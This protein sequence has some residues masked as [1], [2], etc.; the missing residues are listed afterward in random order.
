LAMI[1]AID[2]QVGLLVEALKARRLIDNTVIFF[3]SDNGATQET[4]ADHS[5]RPYRGGSNA[6]YRGWKQ[7][8]FE[9]GVRMPSFVTWP[10]RIKAG[11]TL[12]EIG[13][14]MDVMPTFLTMAGLTPPPDLDGKDQKAM[15]MGQG[16]S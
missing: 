6:P 11:Q 3:Q 15:W 13:M 16:K 9:G 4:R 8:L 5:G 7:G 12:D 14:A 2:D 1:A 10:G